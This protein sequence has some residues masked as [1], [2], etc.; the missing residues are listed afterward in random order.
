ML[1]GNLSL[2]VR[3]KSFNVFGSANYNQSGGTTRESTYRINKDNGIATD[4]FT[5]NSVN[6]RSRKFYSVRV[7]A[8]YFID[9]KTT[10]SFTQGF[11]DGKFSNHEEQNQQYLNSL[12]QLEYNGL[13]YTDGTGSFYRSSSR[14]SFDKTFATPDQKLTADV[15]YN[16]GNRGSGANIVNNYIYPDGTIYQPQSQVRNDG[17]GNNDQ[18]TIQADYSN[19]IN[20]SKRIE[21]GARM[22]LQQHQQPVW[23]VCSKQPGRNKAAPK[24]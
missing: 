4:Y 22:L 18:V 3:Q 17:S 23:N 8:D 14:L 9:S 13:R 5:Q 20:E 11:N 16:R 21:F 1:N 7:G 19:K 6:T 2:N 12:Q 10:L 15:T 24:Q